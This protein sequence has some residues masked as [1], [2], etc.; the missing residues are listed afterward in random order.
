MKS[1][2][3]THT[4]SY[5]ILQYKSS[6]SRVLYCSYSQ[7]PGTVSPLPV[8]LLPRAKSIEYEEHV[9]KDTVGVSP[10]SHEDQKQVEPPRI[11]L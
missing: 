8:H 5:H 10:G 1:L 6:Q 2:I 11:F 9:D 7:V 3:Q 4:L